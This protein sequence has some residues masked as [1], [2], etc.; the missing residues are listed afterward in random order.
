[1]ARATATE[2]SGLDLRLLRTSHRLTVTAVANAA[3]WS[4]Q[5]GS[6]IEATERPTRR[7]I[8]RYL[9]AIEAAAEAR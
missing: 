4:R 2:T 1:M 7:A 3:G 8:A 5:R 6:A 9:A